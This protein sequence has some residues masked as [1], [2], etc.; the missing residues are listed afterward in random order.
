MNNISSNDLINIH[1]TAIM[2][3]DTGV[4]LRGSSGSGKSLLALQLLD[5]FSP[6]S[7][8]IAD[9]RV[10]ILAK[11]NEIYMLTPK[12]IGGLIELRGRGVIKKEY[13]KKAKLHL[14]IDLVAEFDRYPEQDEFFT[15]VQ[16]VNIPRCP[17]PNRQTIDSMHQILLIKAAL[18]LL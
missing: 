3:N 11:N 6:K 1:G 5:L 8:L 18:N 14:I 15:I 17:V 9:D 13:I 4:L 2:I 16:G 7:L 12:N 10:D